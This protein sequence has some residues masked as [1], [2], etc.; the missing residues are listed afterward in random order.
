[1]GE[2][3]YIPRLYL[4]W[5]W[6][7][8]DWSSSWIYV[9]GSLF[10]MDFFC[11]IWSLQEKKD[12]CCWLVVLVWWRLTDWLSLQQTGLFLFSCIWSGEIR[13]EWVILV[14]VNGQ[15]WHGERC[16]T[17]QW[18]WGS[19]QT[20]AL[21]KEYSF[22]ILRSMFRCS[23]RYIQHTILT[24]WLSF[25]AVTTTVVLYSSSLDNEHDILPNEIDNT[26]NSNC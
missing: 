20:T 10:S 24:L 8:I 9:C 25:V 12:R 18:R 14:V 21:G 11:L 2:D 6:C 3:N 22:N 15:S 5:Y 17:Y 16:R 1:M 19:N 13:V 26:P 7:L 23:S 4:D